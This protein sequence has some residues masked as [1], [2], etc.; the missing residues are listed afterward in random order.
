MATL[1]YFIIPKI[2]ETDPR[3]ASLSVEARYLY[4]RMRDTMKLSAM[5]GWNDDLGVFIKMARTTIAN[6]LNKSL[7]TVRKIIRELIEAG[8]IRDVRVGLTHCNRIYVN[9]LPGE[10]ESTVSSREKDNASSKE[11]PVFPTDRK[12]FSLNNNNLVNNNINQNNK[13]GFR[14]KEEKNNQKVG[15]TGHKEGEIWEEGGQK[16]IFSHGYTQRHYTREEL[17]SCFEV[18]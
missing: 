12:G 3:F 1:A 16:Y 14:E 6:I 2:F 15:P 13:T 7:P 5:N 10:S 11:K 17:C 8:L 4:A 18:V 9:L